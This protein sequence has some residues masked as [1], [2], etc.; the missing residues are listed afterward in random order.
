MK[1]AQ[2]NRINRR[3]RIFLMSF[4]IISWHQKIIAQSDIPIGTWR[5]HFS[6]Q[7]ARLLTLTDQQVFVAAPNGLF[8]YDTTENMLSILSR[9]DGLS[10][11][12]VS[13]MA[14]RDNLQLLVLAY[15]NGVV[16]FLQE[17]KI[18]SFTLLHE[19]NS[20]VANAVAITPEG[21]TYLATNQGVRVLNFNQEEFDI[22]ILESYTR[23]GKNGTSLPV[24]DL[25]L[26]QDS[27]F[28]ATEEGI[29]ANTL[30]PGVNQ[31]DFATWRRFGLEE[32]I[33]AHDTFHL[34]QQ[35]DTLYAAVDKVGVYQ[36]LHGIWTL[37]ETQTQETFANLRTSSNALIATTQSQVIVRGREVQSYR[38]PAPNDALQ[39]E[40]G[41]LWVADGTQ[42]LIRSQQ[43]QRTSLFPSGPLSDEQH[44]VY[45]GGDQLLVLQQGK[46]AA[47]SAFSNGEWYLYDSASLATATGQA[48]LSP[49]MD[50]AY[51]P[52][53]DHFY[54][55]T[56]G[57]GII[58]WNGEDAFSLI[59]PDVNNTLYNGFVT[60]IEAQEDALWIITYG[61][62]QPLY[63]FR[64]VDN[65]WQAF[66]PNVSEAR[67][68]TNLAVT[69]EIVWMITGSDSLSKTGN[70][71]IVYNFLTEETKSIRSLTN[72]A[73]LPGGT[74][75]TITKDTQ[76]QLWLTGNEGVS[77]FPAPAAIFSFPDPIKP[78]FENQFMLFG[79]YI[80]S[81]AVDGGNRKWIGT[82]DGIWLFGE[83]GETLVSRFTVDNS[84]LPS[85]NIL[86]LAINDE[87][88]EV[89]ILTDHG[90]VSYRSTATKG[91]TTH[92][93][94]RIFPNPVPFDFT[95]LVGLNGL[96]E[97][98]L[99]KITTVS[100]TLVREIEAE[101]GTAVWDVNDYFGQRVSTGV[102]LVF[103]SSAD[104]S[105]T[106]VGKIAV[107]N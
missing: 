66:S 18:A 100:G 67:F 40:L 65:S 10:S 56:A 58:R 50:V 24:Y 42:G 6:Y 98:A 31:Q 83:V 39:D 21:Q 78:I 9:L 97:N 32:G 19:T 5:T 84:P 2:P 35:N 64:P 94:V 51:S 69:G 102:Y 106:F 20:E 73:S 87:S 105:E 70:N 55:A 54:F 34:A 74:F 71:L 96:V 86:A 99:L 77:Y 13:A 68:A 1:Q 88:G 107:I 15:R 12:D 8:V 30:L 59:S 85:N 41:V 29:I 48:N 63:R 44:S 16:D 4:A 17:G 46:K 89:F 93:M 61:A 3:V 52:A 101:G 60:D 95:G 75:T 25:V 80:T 37:T 62:E 72:T 53:D 90:L 7:D 91:L 11:T 23:L 49:L 22:N 43:G 28:L 33:P 45:Y 104:G 27:I 38:F 82:R 76:G 92:Q 79:D 14:Y 57:S 47:F 36:Y 26:Q 103:S 81:L